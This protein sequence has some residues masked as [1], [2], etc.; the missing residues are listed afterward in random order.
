MLPEKQT[1]ALWQ[2]DADEANAKIK[3]GGLPEAEIDK[4]RAQATTATRQAIAPAASETS[5][6]S[7]Y[8][9]VPSGVGMWN[10][11]AL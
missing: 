11:L 6:F 9:T 5:Q 2:K 1:R 3:A 8:L 10:F 4:L 7:R